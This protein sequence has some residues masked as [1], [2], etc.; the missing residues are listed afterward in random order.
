M[1]DDAGSTTYQGPL[2][3]ADA[4]GGIGHRAATGTADPDF[5]ACASLRLAGAP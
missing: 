2:K 3:R 1:V 5:Q 4:A